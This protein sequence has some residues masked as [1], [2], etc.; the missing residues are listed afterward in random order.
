[1]DRITTWGLSDFDEIMDRAG[2]LAKEVRDDL[3]DFTA[4]KFGIYDQAASMGHDLDSENF[5]DLLVSFAA[6]DKR[7]QAFN[8]HSDITLLGYSQKKKRM[9]GLV[10]PTYDAKHPNGEGVQ[11]FE[12][13]YLEGKDIVLWGAEAPAIHEWIEE[14]G[15]LPIHL[16]ELK[17]ILG[18][19]YLWLDKV[20][21]EYGMDRQRV[22]D[23]GGDILCTSMHRSKVIRQEYV[24]T[25]ED[26]IRLAKKPAGF[27]SGYQQPGPGQA[28]KRVGRNSPCPCG[29]GK[30]YKSCCGRGQ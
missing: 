12:P 2:E 6:E 1:M 13:I 17:A 19:Q 30:K 10:V 9:T 24:G 3:F 28:G 20:A 7:F 8:I 11:A 15:R 27:A 25:M 21:G 16:D 4:H 22:E 29:S 5:I 26:C 14:S 23:C 18:R